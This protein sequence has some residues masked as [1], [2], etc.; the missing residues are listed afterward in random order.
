MKKI[1]FIIIYLFAF[2]I[3]NNLNLNELKADETDSGLWTS[4]AIE[5]SIIKGLDLE[6]GFEYR[7]EEKFSLT[8]QFRGKFSASYKLNKFVKF[9]A[10]YEYHAKK[11]KQD[12]FASR[13]RV[14][15]QGAGSYKFN[16]F[17]V[18]DRFE[19]AWRA[20]LQLT[21]QDDREIDSDFEKNEWVFRNRFELKYDIKNF[22]LNPYLQFE[23]FNHIFDSHDIY[24]QSYYQN[25]LSAGF[26]CSITKQH[27]IDL[28]YKYE[29][30][31]DGAEYLYK[32]IISL[33]Y[34]FKF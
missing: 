1:H 11:K 6:A 19:I 20:R 32:N 21:T 9:G 24:E 22:P 10:G 17:K 2:L 25:R 12:Y 14:F 28:G 27:S 34:K 29:T 13:N 26:E 7:T 4:L 16:H 8:D 3:I 33:G 18:L 15:F 30:E 5:K 23:M 31:I